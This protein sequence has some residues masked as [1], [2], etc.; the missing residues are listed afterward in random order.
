MALSAALKAQ[1]AAWYKALQ[2]QIPDFIP[3]APQR[4]MIADV[5]KT[6]AGEEGRHLAIEAPTGVGKTLSY[7]IPGI[8]IAR[9]EQKTLVIST[10]NVALQDQIFSKDLPLLKKIIPDLRFTA[11]FGRGRYV[12]PR[13]LTA[14]ASSEATQQDLLAFLDD[15][16]TPNSKEEQQRCAKLKADLDSYRW[17]GLR[18]HTDQNIEDNLWR[19]LSTDKASCLNRNCHYYRE[20]PFFV[21]RREV[22]EVEVV[23]ANHALV[24]AAMESEAVLPEPKNLLL[25]LDEGHHLPDVARDALE[26]SA[27][28]TAP[29]YRLQLDLFTKLVATCMEQFRPK[30]TPPLALPERLNAHC[31]ELYELIAS[32]NAILGL[33]MPAGTEA[34]HRFAMGELPDEVMEICL[35]LAKLTEML[36][37]LAEL[38]LNDLSEKTGQHDIVRL[39]RVI[40]QMNRALGMFESQSKLWRLA[41]MAQASGAPVTKWATRELVEGQM[42]LFFH[43]VGIRV[44]DQLEKLLWR[45]VPHIV[46]TS[47]TLR[48]LNSFSRLQEMSG[49]K[50]KAGDRFVSLDSPFNHI[51]QGRLVIPQMRYEPLMEHEEKHIAEMAAYFR[52]QVEKKEHPGML[53]LFASNRAMQLFLTFVTDLRLMLLVQGDQPRYRLVELHRKRIDEGGRSVL[54]GLQSFAEGLDLK[55]D[56]L[57]QVHIHKI[58]F[59]PIDSPVVI[60]EGEW[61]KSLNRYPFEVQSLPSASFNLIQQVGRLI[62]SHSCRGEVVIYDR[63]LLSKGYGKRL[64]DALPVFPISQ[65]DVPDVIVK[66]KPKQNRRRRR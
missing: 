36:R 46:V 45:S 56:Y 31:E 50:E 30:T 35:R 14:L 3:R 24:M 44:S 13:N 57:T 32:L 26:M 23:V 6:L 60:T 40:L 28:I 53:V 27:E 4:Q 17:D 19:R 63:R 65:P 59:P 21:A 43:C 12:C 52:E 64:L 29:W 54:V 7:L 38:F 55:G 48:S 9:E 66:S 8:A 33:Y 62:R 22:Q 11:A 47:A 18:D 2:Q 34:E 10:A 20:C 1:I 16:L 49:L 51:E 41:S 37:G 42:H 25:V 15:E 39:H 58:A 61:L 5:A